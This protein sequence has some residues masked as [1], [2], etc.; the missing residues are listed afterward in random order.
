MRTPSRT[1]KGFTLIE[2]IVVI[3]I[4]GILA[5]FALPKFISMEAPAR[6]SSLNGLQGAILSASALAHGQAL[7]SAQT[8][9]TGNITMEGSAVSLVFGYP[10][11]SAT[12][13]GSAV[14]TSAGSY[15]TSYAG[16]TA[17]YS[18]QTNCNVTFTQAANAT[19]P[20]VIALTTT[21]C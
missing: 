17:T 11:G 16:G 19:T 13:I 4:L 5:A 18:I 9:A 6:A 14:S 8:G 12:G 10:A 1:Q 2:L 20:P 3:V 7:V 15:T 21:G